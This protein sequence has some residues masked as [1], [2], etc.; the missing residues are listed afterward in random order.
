MTDD[1]QPP[2]DL[3]PPSTLPPVE[4]SPLGILADATPPPIRPTKKVVKKVVKKVAKKVP[5]GSGAA[6]PRPPQAKASAPAAQMPA[7]A[8]ITGRTPAVKVPSPS[9]VAT[10]VAK[11]AASR[12]AAPAGGARRRAEQ[13]ADPLDALLD[14][15]PTPPP[16]RTLGS[17]A[18]ASIKGL[19]IIGIA[20]VV[21]FVL[22]QLGYARDG[23]AVAGRTSTTAEATTTTASPFNTTTSM[24]PITTTPVALKNPSELTVQVANAGNLPGTPAG[25]NTTKLRTAGYQTNGAIDAPLAQS[26]VV[27][28]VDDLSGEAA[29]VAK[30]L[31][32][33]PDKIAPMPSPVPTYAAGVDILVELGPDY[34]PSTQG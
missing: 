13:A 12:G 10:G 11:K 31:K 5:S 15:R 14:D 28:Y 1:L 26:T 27:Y 20:L 2:S 34:S 16:A 29:E 8:R 32:I 22:L 25:D 33:A 4:D 30:V 7:S 19:V 21:G 6:P 18:Q 9:P 23:E 17:D 3:P 24:A